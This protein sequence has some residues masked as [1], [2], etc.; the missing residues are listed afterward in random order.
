MRMWN[1]DWYGEALERLLKEYRAG[2]DLSS[3]TTGEARLEKAWQ[4]AWSHAADILRDRLGSEL[5]A[6][7][8]AA[9]WEEPI[10]KVLS[11]LYPGANVRWVGGPQERGADVIVQIPNHFGGLPWLV[12]IQIKNYVGEIDSNVMTQ[13]RIGYDHYSK[14]GKLI[15]LVVMTTAEKASKEFRASADALSKELNIP[16]E[17]ILRK[18]MMKIICD[19]LLTKM[20]PS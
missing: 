1:L 2:S 12:L 5:D 8:Q 6:R 19:G 18:E 10:R 3:A 20:S 11:N 16:V 4:T 7:F 17:A 9:E 14:E 15:S 13:L